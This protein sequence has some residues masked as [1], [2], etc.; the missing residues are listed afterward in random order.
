M[1]DNGASVSGLRRHARSFARHWH[2]DFGIG[3]GPDV[4]QHSRD[5]VLGERP[6]RLQLA[7]RQLERPGISI[8]QVA[9]DAGYE[10][11]AAFNRAFK[12]MMG[13]PPGVWRK[14]RRMLN[15]TGVRPS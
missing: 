12:R 4:V 2:A 6:Q 1:G 13:A 7:A 14:S 9:E 15:G 10:S 11:E 5:L 8:A 3:F